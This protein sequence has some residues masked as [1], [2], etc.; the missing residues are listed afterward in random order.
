MIAPAPC[1]DPTDLIESHV[2]LAEEEARR[3]HRL[4]RRIGDDEVLSAAML[5]LFLAGKGFVE[6]RQ[7]EGGFVSYA[8]RVIASRFQD[9]ERKAGT[10][11]WLNASVFDRESSGVDGTAGQ[12]GQRSE[13]ISFLDSV[14][15]D[16][17]LP[18]HDADELRWGMGRID[19]R[20]ALYLR[21]FYGLDGV[22]PMGYAALAGYFDLTY[23]GARARVRAARKALRAVL[24]RR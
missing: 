10:R 1:A 8:R 22:A 20:Y 19:P 17:Q 3:N 24:A 13:G 9:C 21:M 5:G 14:P 18:S 12:E 4:R 23:D 15:D 6:S 7:G 2:W 16:C 11:Q